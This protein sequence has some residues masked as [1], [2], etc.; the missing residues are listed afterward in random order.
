[1]QTKY[2]KRKLDKKLEKIRKLLDQTDEQIVK[3]LAKR[4]EL[5]REISEM[6][7]S[8]DSHIRDIDREAELLSKITKLAREAGLDRYFAE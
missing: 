8:E 3:S 5:V 2:R 4:Q 6:K 1:M 7:I